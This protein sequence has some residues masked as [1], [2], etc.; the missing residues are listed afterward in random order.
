MMQRLFEPVEISD[1]TL[2]LDMIKEIG[3]GGHHFGTPHTIAR[4]EDAFYHSTIS[5]RQNIGVWEERGRLD[6]TQRAHKVWKELLNNYEKPPMDVAIE[7]E[8][9]E[10]IEK[11]KRGEDAVIL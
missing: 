9:R 2:A 3:P 1:A 7:E 8:L 11:R 6:A 10:Y 4:F 5:D